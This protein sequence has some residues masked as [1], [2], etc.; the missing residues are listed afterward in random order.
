ML[1]NAICAY[2]RTLSRSFAEVAIGKRTNITYGMFYSTNMKRSNRT[3][4][5]L[6]PNCWL[7]LFILIV[8]SVTN[9]SKRRIGHRRYFASGM[10][11]NWT[12]AASSQEEEGP[13]PLSN[14]QHQQLL[15]LDKH[16]SSSPNPDQT[17]KQIAASNNMSEVELQKLLERNRALAA[18]TQSSSLRRLHPISVLSHV[19]SSLVVF[20]LQFAKLYPKRFSMC[21]LALASILYVTY[22]IPRNGVVLSR[23]AVF[24]ISHGF[25]TLYKPPREY[26]SS[27]LLSTLKSHSSEDSWKAHQHSKSQRPTLELLVSEQFHTDTMPWN[28]VTIQKKDHHKRHLKDN[29]QINCYS[30]TARTTVPIPPELILQLLVLRDDTNLLPREKKDD[31]MVDPEMIPQPEYRAELEALQLTAEAALSIVASRRF[32]EYIELNQGNVV[33]LSFQTT[34]TTA[35]EELGHNHFGDYDKKG[36]SA[37]EEVAALVVKTMGDYRRYGIQPLRLSYYQDNTK[38]LDYSN[39]F[40]NGK[41]DQEPVVVLG[42]TTV[43]GGHWDGELRIAIDIAPN[44][45][46]SSVKKKKVKNNSTPFNSSTGSGGGGGGAAVVVVSVSI[47]IPQTSRG[48]KLPSSDTL[49]SKIVTALAESISHSIAVETQRRVAQNI[50]RKRF[51]RQTHTLA[52][53]KRKVRNE[54]IKKLEEMEHDRRRR[55]HN[56]DGGRYRPTGPRLP[57]QTKFS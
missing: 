38:V 40:N 30:V 1:G 8:V 14:R 54:S 51:S 34:S 21:L 4:C 26:I 23:R 42:Y 9:P 37:T 46:T 32:A 44:H 15:Q 6:L 53:D 29:Q 55:R 22:N 19:L 11:A 20:L 48:R 12:P 43:N 35:Q 27:F 7:I 57:Q 18:R 3:K 39:F 45:N 52:M 24:P 17:L 49:S 36:Y 16:I 50:H 2:H 10:E 33:D 31:P 47:I 28:Q 13:L 5:T 41:S 25:T 56:P